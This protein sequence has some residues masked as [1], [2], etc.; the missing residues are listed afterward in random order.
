MKTNNFDTKYASIPAEMFEPVNRDRVLSDQKID[1]KPVG[2]FADAFRRFK[3]NKGAVIASM[4]I[5]VLLLFA[6]IAPYCTPYTIDK[7]DGY[8]KQARP[9]ISGM[10][11]TG[12]GFWDGTYV[13]TQPYQD[14][15][16]FNAIAIGAM[17]DGTDKEIKWEDVVNSQYNPIKKVL[18]TTEKVVV[19]DDKEVLE[20]RYEMR[21]DSYY[22]V[23]FISVAGLTMEEYEKILAW[24]EETGKKVLYPIID[25]GTLE[26]PNAYYNKANINEFYQDNFWYRHD[27]NNNPI[28]EEGNVLT[29]DQIKAGGLVPNYRYGFS[30]AEDG[31]YMHDGT[32][33][34]LITGLSTEEIYSKIKTYSK[35]KADTKGEYAFVDGEYVLASTLTPEEQE[36][37][38]TRYKYNFVKE[39]TNNKDKA[40]YVF[41][42]ASYKKIADLTEDQL[43]RAYA[44]YSATYE[45]SKNGEFVLYEGQYLDCAGWRAITGK[46]VTAWNRLT[47]KYKANYT[48]AEDGEFVFYNSRYV[49]ESTLSAEQKQSMVVYYNLPWND[50]APGTHMYG[51]G[52][53]MEIAGLTMEEQVEMIPKYSYGLMMYKQ[54]G[55][56][57]KNLTVRVLYYNYYQYVNGMEPV[58]VLGADSQGYDILIRLAQGA[59]LSFFLAIIVAIINLFLGIVYGSIQGYYGGKLDLFMEY[60]AEI[61]YEVP[62]IILVMLGKLHFVETGKM[63]Q[64]GALILAFIMT[65]WLGPAYGVRMQFYRFKNQEYVLAARTLGASDFRLIT[66]HI[67]PNAVGTLITSWAFIFPG[68][69]LSETTYSYLGIINFNGSTM[70]S[71][72][73]MLSNGQAAGIDRV[74]HIVFFPAL[75]L[76]LLMISFNLFGNGLR[77]AFNPSLR[78]SED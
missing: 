2:Y 4:I 9:K 44:R 60:F 75:I 43:K 23:G 63:S 68:I 56:G 73:T 66:R 28:D 33:Y 51:N 3:K 20:N 1:T 18:S 6:I 64:F 69:I 72:G 15:V 26:K 31:E 39:K 78:G 54:T 8:Y 45:K 48:L 50:K 36:A 62:T 7:A 61:L 35:F 47:D 34:V 38:P 55:V 21:V 25:T 17:Y 10:D 14:Y 49:R 67:F 40:E 41:D 11:S 13:K 77:D 16:N 37:N 24:E 19:K 57:G 42:G 59:R 12:S 32:D 70:T 74:P 58:F 29:L 52:E 76:S 71:L 5:V 30:E 22:E 27:A 46:D 53:Y 65:G